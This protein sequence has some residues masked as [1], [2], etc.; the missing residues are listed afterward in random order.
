MVKI[1]K[2]KKRD[3]GISKL[4]NENVSRQD[5]RWKDIPKKEKCSLW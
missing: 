1:E 3:L 5:K 2:N 4:Q